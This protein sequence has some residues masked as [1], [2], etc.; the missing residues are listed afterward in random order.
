MN[1]GKKPKMMGRTIPASYACDN[2]SN[3]PYL[4]AQVRMPPAVVKSRPPAHRALSVSDILDEII[5]RLPNSGRAASARVSSRWLEPSL[6]KLWKNLNSIL[7]LLKLVSALSD[8]YDGRHI[9]TFHQPPRDV[10]WSRFTSYTHRIRSIT[11]SD[12][13]GTLSNDIFAQIF[14]HR[15]L[16]HPLL[17]SIQALTW[18]ASCDNTVIHLL[19]LA[20]ESLKTLHL[21][22]K[23]GC[24]AESVATTLKGL[25]D[26]GVRLE[27]LRI[28]AW[29][30]VDEIEVTLAS[31]LCD[32]LELKVVGLPQYYGTKELIAVLGSL[33][34]LEALL[35]TNS[36]REKMGGMNWQLGEGSLKTLLSFGFNA[37][38]TTAKEIL[39]SNSFSH[40]SHLSVTPPSQGAID[41]SLRAFFSSLPLSCPGL[42]FIRL[43]L[44]QYP[45][46]NNGFTSSGF[47]PLFHLRSLEVLE[48]D[49]RAPVIGIDQEL[50][51]DMARFWPSLRR[52]RITPEP[53]DAVPDGIGNSLS[54]LRA[55]AH[56][57]DP[58]SRCLESI[59]L[60]F[61]VESKP[62]LDTRGINV[63][64]SLREFD[65]GTSGIKQDDVFSVVTFLGGL[66]CPG[67]TIRAGR[68]SRELNYY[69]K[70]AVSIWEQ[71]GASLRVLHTL[72][73]PLRYRLEVLESEA[74][75]ARGQAASWR[76]RRSKDS[77]KLGSITNL[78]VD[79]ERVTGEVTRAEMD[80]FMS[81]FSPNP[82]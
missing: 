32:Q 65:V 39:R 36:L 5:E 37:P 24:S 51:E 26:R 67:L 48:F 75:K 40:L 58:A 50:V 22:I 76:Q 79:P 82:T 74:R 63:F 28:E 25:D 10:R 64:P 70:Q 2:S 21:Q 7:P 52:L 78:E 45:S 56:H 66:C 57:F 59:G 49:D 55:F 19:P 20:C 9:I 3:F 60:Y 35:T 73:S 41:S 17:P 33:P 69:E 1:K 8:T 62:L 42:R 71:A 46:K 12:D 43:D 30:D 27:D 34:K 18:T 72:Q 6:E 81:A 23:D 31:F 61:K 68:R 80:G 4:Q 47:R 29:F 53:S 14:L 13:K 44:C 11:W 54:I 16:V 15:P 77:R 38:L